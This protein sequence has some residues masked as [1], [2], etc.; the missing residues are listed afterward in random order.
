MWKSRMFWQLFGFYALLLLAAVGV[1]GLL[2]VSRVERQYLQL[3]HD[4]LHDAALYAQLAVHARADDPDLQKHV[5]ALR[6]KSRARLTLI[7]ADGRVLADSD[8]EPGRSPATPRCARPARTAWARAPATAAP[9]V[10]A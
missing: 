7:D 4:K 1:P 10:K 8:E 5:A 2:L 9:S 6:G 3:L